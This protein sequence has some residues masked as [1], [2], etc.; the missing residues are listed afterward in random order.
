[1]VIKKKESQTKISQTFGLKLHNDEEILFKL[2]SKQILL[3]IIF[4]VVFIYYTYLILTFPFLQ[5]PS[6]P[7]LI[8]FIS[9]FIILEIA[10]LLWRQFIYIF[11]SQRILFGKLNK[12]YSANYDEIQAIVYHKELILCEQIE[13]HLKNSLQEFNGI[14]KSKITINSRRT[15]NSRKRLLTFLYNIKR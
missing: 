10:F 2:N 12:I 3:S 9:I 6:I 4:T 5:L 1:M 7:L 14:D 11:T 13:I 8:T 15:F